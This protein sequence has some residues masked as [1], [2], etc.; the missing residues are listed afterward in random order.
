MIHHPAIVVRRRSG[1]IDALVCAILTGE[2]RPLSVYDIA[3][4]AS[5]DG[6]RVVPAQVYRTLAR[7]VCQRRVLRVE[8]LG[9]YV[10]RPPLADLCLVCLSCRRVQLIA[11]P[12][13]RVI[14]TDATG[15]RFRLAEAPVE[16][17]GLCGACDGASASEEPGFLTGEV[18]NG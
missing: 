2:S 17:G 9:A 15:R 1:E 5:K 7:L 18:H 14:Q 4:Q 8:M 10:L 13:L 11:N 12:A 16:A 6:R 3:G